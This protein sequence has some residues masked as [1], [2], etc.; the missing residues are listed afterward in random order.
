MIILIHQNAQQVVKV[1]KGETE[2]KISDTLCTKNFW[3]LAEKYPDEMIY[4]CEEEFF[5]Y[6]DLEAIH[7]IFPHDLIMASYA[8][9]HSCLPEHIG[10]IDQNPYINVNLKVRYGTWRMS[11]DAGGIKGKT[12]LKFRDNFGQIKDFGFLL[13]SVAK[14]GQHNGLFCYSDPHFFQAKLKKKYTPEPVAGI[15]GLFSFVYM[16]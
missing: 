15:P 12:L 13:N 11:T 9:K 1:L 8:L 10:Y 5:Q 14:L 16:H 2:I 3:E 7:E 4:W 6:L